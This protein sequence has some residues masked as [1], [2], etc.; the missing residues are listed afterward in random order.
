MTGH[1]IQ[2]DQIIWRQRVEVELGA[3]SGQPPFG[4]SRRDASTTT[5]GFR[6]LNPLPDTDLLVQQVLLQSPKRTA[7]DDTNR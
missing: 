2:V 6:A 4:L 5:S 7:R 1:E 3:A